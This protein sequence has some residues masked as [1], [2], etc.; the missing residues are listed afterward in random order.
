MERR[1]VLEEGE[2]DRPRADVGDGH[3]ELLLGLG[4]DRLGRCQR[5][6]HQLVDLDP[7]GGDALGQV[8]D[9]RGGRRDDVGLDLEPQRAHP[10][11][12][13]DALLAVDREAA[14]FDVQDVA[15]GRDRDRPGDLDGAVDVLAGDL[16]VMGGD[17]DLAAR[18]E[19]LDVLAADAHERPVDLP[20]GQPFGALDGVGDRADGLV[21]VDD[22]AL[23]ETRGGHGAVAHDRQPAVA[24]HLADEG[25]DLARADV[26]ADEDRFSFHRF[27]RLRSRFDALQEMAPD[28]CHVIE[29]AQAEGDQGYQVEIEAQPIPDEGQQ[30]GDDRIDKE[31]ADEDPIVVDPVEL[32]PDGPEHRIERGEDRH[33]RIAT[34]LETDIDIEDES[35][36]DAHEESQQR[37][38]HGVFVLAP[39]VSARLPDGTAVRHFRRRRHGALLGAADGVARGVYVP[40]VS[41]A[42]ITRS[43]SGSRPTS[44][45]RRSRTWPGMS[46]VVRRLGV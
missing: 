38:Q 39:V 42:R 33:R 37:K 11:R 2:V 27:S 8:L 31:P 12:V 14:P 3:A 29:D 4:Q 9:R 17:R 26:D 36:Q 41:E 25:A 28:E 19:A 23:L 22:D 45:L 43:T 40:S 6:D 15:V 18:V 21:D 20:A 1:A 7:G 30:N 16:A 32:R 24:A 10:E 5:V 34:E 35:Q 44:R 46:S 13:L